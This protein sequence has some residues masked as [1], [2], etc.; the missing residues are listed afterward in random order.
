LSGTL[1]GRG[2]EAKGNAVRPR[3]FFTLTKPPSLPA[4]K[5][6]RKAFVRLQT[7]ISSLSGHLCCGVE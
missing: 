5:Y 2:C 1:L 4:W 6:H 3:I 7:R